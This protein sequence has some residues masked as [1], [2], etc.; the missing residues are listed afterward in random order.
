MF[1]RKRTSRY[2]SRNSK[3]ELLDVGVS[4]PRLLY[5][6]SKGLVWFSIRILAICG[7]IAAAV[8]GGVIASETY[9]MKNEEFLLKEIEL[10]TNG[11]FTSQR[12]VNETRIKEGA[13]LFELD[14]EFMRSELISLP[15]VV[16]VKIER[17]LPSRL[18]VVLTERVPV[19]W[20][21]AEHLGLSGHDQ[22]NGL[23]IGEEG[24]LFSAEGRLAKVAKNLPVIRL[25]D[26]DQYSI[27]EAQKIIH[28][29]CL[30]A[31]ELLK[32][33]TKKCSEESWQ[34]KVVK[35]ENFY[36]LKV[37][38]SDGVVANFGMH[39][40]E[41]QLSD[42]IDVREH[43]LKLSKQLESLDLRPKTTIP[44]KYRKTE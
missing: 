13:T 30:R 17:K 38:Y 42:L 9:F 2:R 1:R 24:Y 27:R 6:R 20:V 12:V 28:D 21:E 35:V 16:D 44:G 22:E 19:A 14:L 39:D 25:K 40:H 41:R 23:L 34:P 26:G 5:L 3:S 8:W 31:V 11:T 37:E 29:E 7:V 18:K 10:E 43:A 4:S 36:T 32:L 33:H 15:E